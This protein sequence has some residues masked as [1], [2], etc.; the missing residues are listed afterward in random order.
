MSSN[1]PPLLIEEEETLMPSRGSIVVFLAMFIATVALIV[2]IL[3]WDHSLLAGLF[4]GIAFWTWVLAAIVLAFG[5]V[6]LAWRLR[7]TRARRNAL[8]H[9][10]W[11]VE[12]EATSAASRRDSR[13]S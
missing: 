10:E 7:R 1:P 3:I 6:T 5:P 8:L 12:D 13:E 11:V 2:V 9:A 4:L